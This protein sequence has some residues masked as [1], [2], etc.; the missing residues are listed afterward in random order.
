LNHPLLFLNYPFEVLP[1]K[2][3]ILK[4][5]DITKPLALRLL[6]EYPEILIWS[7]R[8]LEA[9]AI[10]LKDRLALPLTDN[11]LEFLATK[12]ENVIKPR[13]DLIIKSKYPLVEEELCKL[14][15]MSD[16]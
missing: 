9:K 7:M 6:K 13:G 5:L 8:S 2:I 12:Y 15:K 3:K 16:E 4:Y 10:F 11:T 1:L 14:M